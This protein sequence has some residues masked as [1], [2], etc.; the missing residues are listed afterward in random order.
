VQEATVALAMLVRALSFAPRRGDSDV[1]DL[2]SQ[3]TLSPRHP[4]RLVVTRA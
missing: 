1:L 2:L 4:V 3:I